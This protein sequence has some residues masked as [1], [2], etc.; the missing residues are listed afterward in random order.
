MKKLFYILIIYLIVFS[1]NICDA[2]ILSSASAIDVYIMEGQSLMNGSNSAI[3]SITEKY[4]RK[5]GNVKIW[6]GSS[7]VYL[8]PQVNNN[9]Q[10]SSSQANQFSYSTIVFQKITSLSKN[11]IY[12]IQYAKGGTWLYDTTPNYTSWNATKA[13][14]LYDSAR[15]WNKNAISYLNSNHIPYNIRAF[16]WD[17][18]QT[19]GSRLNTSQAY[20][21]NLKT[22]CDSI[23]QYLGLSTLPI[24][25][26]RMH[27]NSSH[28]SYP[29]QDTIR[30]KQAAYVA[31]DPY[32]ILISTDS[33][34]LGTDSIHLNPSG[35]IAMGEYLAGILPHSTRHLYNL[36]SHVWMPSEI[37]GLR[38]WLDFSDLSTITKNND[39]ISNIIDKSG[40]ATPAYAFAQSTNS[41]KPVWVLDHAVFDG[42][43]DFLLKTTTDTIAGRPYTVLLYIK[44]T[45]NNSFVKYI[46]DIQT[47][48]TYYN[49]KDAIGYLNT[50]VTANNDSIANTTATYHLIG[51]N[52]IGSNTAKTIYGD[53]MTSITLTNSYVYCGGNMGIA[54]TYSGAS[55]FAAINV[56]AVFIING[57]IS[58]NN[59][60]NL[61]NYCKTKYTH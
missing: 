59:L 46:F 61:N 18:G 52:A 6:N 8:D 50:A 34:S 55:S 42:S 48:R 26:C 44:T 29:Y 45:Q 2:Q 51:W 41:K 32:S 22:Y 12:I 35:N 7:F 19:D 57:S 10:P 15:T 58:Q 16:V 43:N 25:I 39:S 31:T 38:L 47:T 27:N 23:R 54:S 49:Y 21:T 28:I 1:T 20:Q 14:G 3:S 30:A 24:Y 11:E 13:S 60:T 37:P 9:Q 4:S 56:Y 40:Y 33:Y 5:N 53:I 17:Q 36:N